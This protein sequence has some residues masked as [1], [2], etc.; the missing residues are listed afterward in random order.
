MR[1][2]LIKYLE[3]GDIFMMDPADQVDFALAIKN[4]S[5]EVCVA[6]CSHGDEQHIFHID[7]VVWIHV[8]E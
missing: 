1:R 6:R 4:V 5:A 8:K 3:P 2:T 7:A